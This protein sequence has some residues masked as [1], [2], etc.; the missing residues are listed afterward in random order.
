MTAGGG[1]EGGTRETA[2]EQRRQERH[3]TGVVT[4]MPTHARAFI[5]GTMPSLVQRPR[6]PAKEHPI[7]VGEQRLRA[8]VGVGQDGAGEGHK[9][10]QANH[11]G[12]ATK[13]DPGAPTHARWASGRLHRAT[14]HTLSE[15]L[16]QNI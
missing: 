4:L 8:E 1:Q 12:R 10:R 6:V 7:S 2:L 3:E 5:G 11:E 14:N 15:R 16:K 13:H 9:R